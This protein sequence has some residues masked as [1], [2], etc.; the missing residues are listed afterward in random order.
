[1]RLSHTMHAMVVCTCLPLRTDE[2]DNE[3]E[4]DV[5]RERR[6][7]GDELV[8]EVLDRAIDAVVLRTTRRRESRHA[9]QQSK[10]Q[11]EAKRACLCADHATVGASRRPL[12]VFTHL[13]AIIDAVARALVGARPVRGVDEVQ[14]LR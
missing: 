6:V 11:L 12:C 4:R 1:M 9:H 14:R 7:L 13:H 8:G 10:D 2:V 5:H 3:L